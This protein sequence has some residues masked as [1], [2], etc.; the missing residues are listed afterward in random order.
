[1]K[2]DLAVEG[3]I[4]ATSGGTFRADV[5]VQEGKILAV[6]RVYDVEAKQKIDAQ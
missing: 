1:M 5:Y 6:G 2:G 3:G 4:V